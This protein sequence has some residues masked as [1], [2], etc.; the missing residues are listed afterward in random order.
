M[1]ESKGLGSI[2]LERSPGQQAA[3]VAGLVVFIALVLWAGYQLIRPSYQ[4]LFSGLR[5]HDAA[6][7]VG[8]LERQKI[9]YR[10]DDGGTTILVPQSQVHA[11]RLKV[12]SRDLP[13]KG[14]VGFELFNNADL[15]LTEF[16]QKVN[17]QR[18]LQGEIARTIMSLDEVDSARVHLTLPEAGLFR[19]NNAKPRASVAL[20]LKGGGA[21]P[22]ESVRGIQ[23]LVAAAVPELEA[24]EVTIV[25]TRGAPMGAASAGDIV[26]DRRLEMK[27]EVEQYY[28]RK[29][30]KLIEPIVGQG[31][32]SV[33]VDATL[34]FDQIRVT[35]E[36]SGAPGQRQRPN[37][38]G[39][40]PLELP[41][42]GADGLQASE[43]SERQR[44]LAGFEG[45]AR[46]LEQI[47][48]APGG[49]KRLS[50]GVLVSQPLESAA[51]DQIRQL[52]IATAG[53]SAERGDTVVF[54]SRDAF[55]G[56]AKVPEPGNVAAS[57]LRDVEDASVP[58]RAVTAASGN[59]WLYD[60]KVWFLLIASGAT[61]A[62]V[63][64]AWSVRRKHV[65]FDRETVLEQLRRSLP[66][67]GADAKA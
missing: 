29:L 2:W 8:E 48:A 44:G 64:V 22:P 23:R 28:A 21:L 53:L 20:T 40:R 49:I 7:I 25:D 47:V 4:P 41:A 52:V 46:R 31:N 45:N 24:H 14:T 57:A 65:S 54:F 9:D 63:A 37:A 55:P 56:A 15:G 59:T 67:A 38:G 10:L 16:A 18:A 26:T 50:V 27:I 61:L 42:A 32:A 6:T 13:L 34:S 12:M 51:M 58:E 17:Y 30:L 3:L 66:E 60:W 39:V 1:A 19:R 33:S 5:P 36:M 11:A 35:Q 62:L 43:V